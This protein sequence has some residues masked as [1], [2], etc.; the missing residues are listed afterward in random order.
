MV[1]LAVD[2]GGYFL[3]RQRALKAAAQGEFLDTKSHPVFHKVVYALLL[4]GLVPCYTA[5]MLSFPFPFSIIIALLPVCWVGILALLLGVR[6]FLKRKKASADTNFMVTYG[7]SQVL[8]V[9]ILGMVPALAFVAG[10]ADTWRS[11]PPDTLPLTLAELAEIPEGE[12]CRWDMRSSGTFLLGYVSTRQRFQPDGGEETDG[13]WLDYSILTVKLPA[14]YDLCRDDRLSRYDTRNNARVPE[15]EKM[16][17]EPSD[18]APWG[19]EAAYQRYHQKYGLRSEFLLCYQGRF[20][21]ISFDD[22]WQLSREQ[23]ELVGERL[24]GIASRQITIPERRTDHENQE[25]AGDLYFL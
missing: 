11:S 7:V 19:A 15:G 1:K 13:I 16:W 3:W 23:M 14:L 25:K 6:R 22:D 8:G 9:F 10:Q 2:L 20:V 17:Y 24:G 18:P 12:D 5:A 4:A 21:E